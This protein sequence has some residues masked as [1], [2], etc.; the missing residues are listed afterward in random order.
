M[1]WSK[2]K[3]IVLLLLVCVN[4]AL[5][6]FLLQGE[7]RARKIQ[8][9]ARSEAIVFLEKKGVT[10]AEEDIPQAEELVPRVVERDLEWEGELA[11]ALLGENIQVQDRGA[12]VY[13][14][15]G[16]NGTIQ[17]HSDGAFSGEF[18]AGIFPAGENRAET[19]LALLRKLEFDGVLLETR[20]NV[21]TFRQT[22]EEIPLFSQQVTLEIRDGCVMTM[23][24]GRRLV[25]QPAEDAG[26]DTMTVSTALIRF[27]NGMNELG[28]VCSRIDGVEQGYVSSTSLSGPMQLTPVWRIATDTDEYQMDLVTGALSRVA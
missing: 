2:L 10:V 11:R 1:E 4:V 6:S 15:S 19:C 5:L 14:Y 17:F 8:S 7:I 16:A 27:F 28:G 21:L 9:Q 23:T 25:G 3:N 24:A 13:R 20:G 26:R 18:A 22:W 12:G